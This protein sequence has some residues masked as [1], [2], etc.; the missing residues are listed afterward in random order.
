MLDHLASC[1]DTQR[2]EKMVPADLE[3]LV[4]SLVVYSLT[5]PVGQRTIYKGRKIV[6]MLV[7][8]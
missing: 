1:T 3:D 4:A 7:T 8:Q 5:S 6:L 2:F